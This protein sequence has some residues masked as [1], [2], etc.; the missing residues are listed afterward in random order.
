[1]GV[2]HIESVLTR[3]IHII[4]QFIEVFHYILEMLL[5]LPERAMMDLT[6]DGRKCLQ[7]ENQL[8][9]IDRA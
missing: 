2:W 3:T 5:Q 4:I 1:M 9:R 7:G 8:L 6:A